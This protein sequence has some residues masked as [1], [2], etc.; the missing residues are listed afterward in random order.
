MLSALRLTLFSLPL[1]L[2]AGCTQ[3]PPP[4]TQPIE[5]ATEVIESKPEILTDLVA[6][7]V[8]SGICDQPLEFALGEMNSY[9]CESALLQHWSSEIPASGIR[10]W[11][12]WCQSVLAPQD[13]RKLEIRYGPNFILAQP[14]NLDFDI[15]TENLCEDLEVSGGLSGAASTEA[16]DGT[17]WSLATGF[18]EAGLC[19]EMPDINAGSQLRIECS[20]FDT[21]DGFSVWLE[22]GEV[23]PLAKEYAAECGSG[24]FGTVGSD[25][26]VS[27]YDQENILAVSETLADRLLLA[28][29]VPFDLL[30]SED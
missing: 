12:V 22:F 14:A 13:E 18:A 20:G 3:A 2:V 4:V 16:G 26:L 21:E 27:T 29:P 19:F 6:Q 11:Q 24:V 17:P 5:Q 7:L 28:S 23:A 25:W 1:V 9:A 8:S 15:E 10:P 30:C